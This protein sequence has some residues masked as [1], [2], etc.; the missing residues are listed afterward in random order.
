MTPENTYSTHLSSNY[1][2]WLSRI[3]Y[4]EKNRQNP[5]SN[6]E[7]FILENTLL[8]FCLLSFRIPV[9]SDPCSLD[10]LTDLHR[11]CFL[12]SWQFWCV[13]RLI[14]IEKYKEIIKHL[15][16]DLPI[17]QKIVLLLSSIS[18]NTILSLL[19]SLLILACYL[20]KKNQK[21]QKIKKNQTKLKKK[22]FKKKF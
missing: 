20:L 18:M 8:I 16:W 1:R 3:N 17:F 4:F 10:Q 11:R 9:K 19:F 2:T 7:H 5:S 14:L 22:K 21:N 6:L 13:F 12:P 15:N